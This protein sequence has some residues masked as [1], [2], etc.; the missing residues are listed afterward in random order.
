MA[1]RIKDVKIEERHPDEVRMVNGQ[2]VTVPTAKVYNPAFDITPPELISAIITD[3]G[4]LRRPN[5]EK[6]K[7][8]FGTQASKSARPTSCD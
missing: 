3:R 6:M 1:S 5:E 8:L 2:Y 4:V 7:R